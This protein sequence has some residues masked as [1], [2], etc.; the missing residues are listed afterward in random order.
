MDFCI[1]EA[2]MGADQSVPVGIGA[3]STAK[4]VSSRVEHRKIQ[5]DQLLL[6]SVGGGELWVRSILGGPHC[7]S[8]RRK[9]WNWVR[10]CYCSS[11]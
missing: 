11:V 3:H 7:N 4:E 2:T 10:P 9:Q 6:A 5:S 1:K 8:Y